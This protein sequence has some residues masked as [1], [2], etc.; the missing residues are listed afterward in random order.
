MGC[1]SVLIVSGLEPSGAAGLLLDVQVIRRLGFWPIAL[2]TC[3]TCQLKGKVF[4]V[5]P[6]SPEKLAR[7][8]AGYLP[9]VKAVKIGL[10]PTPPVAGA[11]AEAMKGR[12]D[13]RAVFDP[14]LSTSAGEPTFWGGTYD[15]LFR[16]M[17]EVELVTPNLHEAKALAGT[18]SDDP[19]VLCRAVVGRGARAVL[20][21]GGHSAERGV[22]LFFDGKRLV[23]VEPEAAIDSDIRG[24]G[25][26]LSSAIAAQLAGGEELIDAI[27]R[28]KRFWESSAQGAR[29][30]FGE[31]A[32]DL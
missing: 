11:I 16:L 19:E 15:S 7:A 14:V 9:Y 30:L 25:C 22:D 12:G 10:V 23:R 17:T 8:I 29:E 32:F 13:I 27:V 18:G 24:S 28:A 2:A 4:W 20:L 3:T 6:E 1:E 21:K 31:L 5:N 26:L